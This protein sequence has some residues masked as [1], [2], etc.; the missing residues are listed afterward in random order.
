MDTFRAPYEHPISS[1]CMSLPPPHFAFFGA[2]D[3][4]LFDYHHLSP[5]L[6]IPKDGF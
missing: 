6:Y 4:Q 5:S 3:G 2:A 1:P